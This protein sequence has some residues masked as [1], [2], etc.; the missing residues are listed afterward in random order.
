MG[1]V[2][3][4]LMNPNTGFLNNTLRSLGLGFLANNWIAD[5]K[6]AIHCTSIMETWRATGISMAIYLAGLQAIP[7]EYLEAAIIDGAS[8]WKRFKYVTFP[9]LAPSVTINVILC[10]IYG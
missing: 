5:P 2:F 9:L 7:S 4:G 3:K 8:S 6:M 1:L 10:L